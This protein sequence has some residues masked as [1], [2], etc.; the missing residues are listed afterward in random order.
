MAAECSVGVILPGGRACLPPTI[1]NHS[2][3]NWKLAALSACKL[4]PPSQP[5]FG[6]LRIQALPLVGWFIIQEIMVDYRE[7]P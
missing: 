7:N 1:L 4:P 6:D 3:G 5:T 2:L